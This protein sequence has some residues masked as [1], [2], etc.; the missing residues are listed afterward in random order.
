LH[1]TENTQEIAV[2]AA[3]DPK[4]VS[5][6][7]PSP[8]DRPE[9]DILLFDGH[10]RFCHAAVRRLR[11]LDTRGRIAYLSL[12]EPEVA[13]RWPDLSHE[14]LLKD[15]YLIDR[16]GGKHRGAEAYRYMSTRLP[17]LWPLAPLLHIPGSMPLWQFLYQQV[18]KRR[19]LLFGKSQSCNDGACS[20]H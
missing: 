5:N 8:T 9:A 20:I 10:C 15:M 17:W 3:S 14:A 19:Y 13:E 2:A 6:A 12:H 11:R 16:G 7:L 1:Y 4:T 18:A